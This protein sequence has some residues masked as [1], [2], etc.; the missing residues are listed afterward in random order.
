MLV[1]MPR[2]ALASGSSTTTQPS[3]T[4]GIGIRL[5]QEPVSLERD[6]RARIYIIDHLHPGTTIRRKIA[7]SNTTS[8]PQHVS[9]YAGGAEITDDVFVPGPNNTLTSWIKVSPSSVELQPGTSQDAEVTIAVPPTA[10][11]GEGLAVVWASVETPGSVINQINRVGIR[12]YLDVGPGGN[13]PTTFVLGPLTVTTSKAG[14][15]VIHSTVDNTGARAIDVSGNLRMEYPPG[16]ISV[17]PYRLDRNPTVPPHSSSALAIT[18]PSRLPIGEWKASLRAMADTVT[19]VRSGEIAITKGAP[20]VAR[21]S[22]GSSDS[23][24]LIGGIVAVVVVALGGGF[25][26]GRRSRRVVPA[27]AKRSPAGKGASAR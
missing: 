2:A 12:V 3:P 14:R 21:S 15:S 19:N 17:G 10:S 16:S 24:Y 11:Q 6:P 4:G 26:F 22:S 27:H 13:P 5:L 8:S 20:A 25:Y 9:L 7:V 1:A 23:A 18:L